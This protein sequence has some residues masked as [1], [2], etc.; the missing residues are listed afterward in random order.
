MSNKM[1]SMTA[2]EPILNSKL[3]GLPMLA[4]PSHGF[5]LGILSSF[6][7]NRAFSIFSTS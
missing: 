4:V 2:S 5:N 1:M 6:L 3:R 7:G